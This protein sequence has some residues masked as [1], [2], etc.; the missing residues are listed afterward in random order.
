MLRAVAW[1]SGSTL[2]KSINELKVTFYTEPQGY[3][4]GLRYCMEITGYEHLPPPFNSI[5]NQLDT[6]GAQNY[7]EGT[8]KVKRE[9]SGRENIVFDTYALSLKPLVDALFNGFIKKNSEPGRYELSFSTLMEEAAKAVPS[10]VKIK[11][12]WHDTKD[13]LPPPEGHEGPA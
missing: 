11:K 3:Q 5:I 1:D 6:Y 13:G 8:F 4:T 10:G 9:D 12:I 7:P 2:E